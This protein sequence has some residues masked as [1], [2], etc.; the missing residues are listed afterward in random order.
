MLYWK[1]WIWQRTGGLGS[2]SVQRWEPK[3]WTSASV[4]APGLEASWHS[5][6]VVGSRVRQMRKGGRQSQMGR[7]GILCPDEEFRL[8]LVFLCFPNFSHFDTTTMVLNNSLTEVKSKSTGATSLGLYVSFAIYWQCDLG[9]ITYPALPQPLRCR[10][11]IVSH[12]IVTPLKVCYC[13]SSAYNSTWHG[14]KTQKLWAA[15]FLS[16]YCWKWHFDVWLK[17]A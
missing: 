16:M 1:L 12:G 13:M 17:K 2:G 10:M 8:H 11:E 14:G 5:R 6:G 4:K 3:Q 15:I 9:Q 7:K